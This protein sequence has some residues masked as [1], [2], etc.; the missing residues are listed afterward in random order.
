[1]ILVLLVGTR[2]EIP[3]FLLCTVMDMLPK[4]AV[5]STLVVCR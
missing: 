1:M 4:H 5:T 2:K 3:E